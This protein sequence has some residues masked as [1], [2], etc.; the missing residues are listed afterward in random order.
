MSEPTSEQSVRRL[1]TGILVRAVE[2]AEYRGRESER[3]DARATAMEFLHSG[4]ARSM[5]AYLGVPGSMFTARVAGCSDKRLLRHGRFSRRFAPPV[6]VTRKE[7]AKPE[8]INPMPAGWFGKRPVGCKP[9]PIAPRNDE[10]R[11]YQS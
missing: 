1:L 10:L 5:G 7:P 11:I 2:D 8:R 9:M 4:Q 3:R 6:S